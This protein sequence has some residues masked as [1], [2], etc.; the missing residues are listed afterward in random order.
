ML[1]K[2][3]PADG[4]V[5]CHA[6]ACGERVIVGSETS[7]SGEAPG[8]LGEASAKMTVDALQTFY[9]VHHSIGM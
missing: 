5:F 7:S 1:R 8:C 3:I 6:N 4:K 9:W 2:E